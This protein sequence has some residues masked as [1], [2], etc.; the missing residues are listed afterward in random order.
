MSRQHW[1]VCTD[2]DAGGGHRQYD[3]GSRA[4]SVLVRVVALA[5]R[6]HWIRHRQPVR[7]G[8]HTHEEV[9]QRTS[10]PCAVTVGDVT[11]S[12]AP[13]RSGE[14][15]THL[16]FGARRF[17]Y[18]ISRYPEFVEFRAMLDEASDHAWNGQHFFTVVSTNQEP[19]TRTLWLM[20]REVSIDFSEGEW[21]ALRDLVHEA[22]RSADLQRWVQALDQEYGEQ[23]VTR[24]PAH[25]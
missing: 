18:L 9:R 4:G 12:F 22:W 5:A 17:S 25:P 15:A 21:Q 14:F 20:R 1:V 23:G 10:L 19:K 8:E 3:P 2:R 13:S 6:G 7:V 24:C 11:A 16:A